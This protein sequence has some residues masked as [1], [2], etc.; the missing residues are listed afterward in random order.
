MH[1]TTFALV[2]LSVD[3]MYKKFVSINLWLLGMLV[4]SPTELTAVI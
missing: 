4:S 3:Q 1:Y 2:G